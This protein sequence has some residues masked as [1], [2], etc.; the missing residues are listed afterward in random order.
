MFRQLSLLEPSRPTPWHRGH[1]ALTVRESLRAK[2]LILQLV[3]P[4]TLELVVPRG[5]RPKIVEAFV[6]EHRDWIERARRELSESAANSQPPERI[7]LAAIGRRWRIEYR[8]GASTRSRWAMAG[9]VLVLRG[10]DPAYRDGPR[11]L[12]QW[13]LEQARIHLKPW[14]AGE[15]R[16]CGLTPSKVHVR[17][18]KTRW[19]SCSAQGIISLNASLLFLAP[20]L[21][22]YLFVHELSHLRVLNHSRRFWRCVERFAPDYEVLDQRLAA[23]WTD[24]PY[25]VF[26]GTRECRTWAGR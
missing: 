17:L 3:P 22:R 4:H 19:G 11:L 26:A 8:P 10:A 5:T 24:V 15:A 20:E 6:R 25:W 7:V 21:V 14:L 2:R 1:D 13:L 18:Q 12:R 23:A 16:R 9:D